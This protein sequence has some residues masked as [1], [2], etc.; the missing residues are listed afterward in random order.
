M[1]PVMRPRL[2]AAEALLPYL[3]RIDQTRIY[4]NMG[5]L[6]NL[7]AERLGRHLG[8]EVLPVA[9]AT[10]GL[11]VALAASVPASGRLCLMPSWTFAASGHAAQ[12]AGLTP[13]LVDVCPHSQAL[14]PKQALDALQKAPEQ[15]AAVMV[16][17]PFGAPL[18]PLPWQDFRNRTQIPVVIDA[19]AGFDSVKVSAVPTV[20]SLHATKALGAGEGGF[21]TCTDTELM[22]RARAIA[23]F[24]FADGKRLASL[25][26]F[27]AK[28]SEYQ[29]A[30]ALTA[31][32]HWP[33]TRHALATVLCKLRQVL[34]ESKLWWPD[35]LG[36]SWVVSTT[37]LLFSGEAE[38]LAAHCLS[39]G[40][41]TRCWWGGGLHDQPA[42]AACPTLALRTT[43]DLA[44]RSIGLPCYL[45]MTDAEIDQIARAVA[46]YPG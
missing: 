25:V 4:S 35:G 3:R 41:A 2:P 39:Q 38:P 20:V 28:I 45:D 12:A 46:T 42:F 13:F 14:T 17:A 44:R 9:N 33:Q 32:D 22:N 24:G 37:A 23:N 18:D 19:A 8:G 30:V 21:I 6:S 5:P 27:N 1:I 7:L 15:V 11:S 31:L 16:V 40:I 10:L 43:R 26:G 36:G 34:P 29:A